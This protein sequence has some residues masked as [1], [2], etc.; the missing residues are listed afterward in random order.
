MTSRNYLLQLIR[1]FEFKIKEQ[2]ISQEE[3]SRLAGEVASIG[4]KDFVGIGYKEVFIIAVVIINR[5]LVGFIVI[6]MK[7]TGFVDMGLTVEDISLLDIA[8]NSYTTSFG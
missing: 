2:A 7:L 5:E 3:A 8:P 1:G 6:N 4:F